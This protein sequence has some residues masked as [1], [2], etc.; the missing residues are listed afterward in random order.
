MCFIALTAL[1]SFR[2]KPDSLNL[3]IKDEFIQGWEDALTAGEEIYYNG[4]LNGMP[5]LERVDPTKFS[6]DR[7]PNLKNVEDGEWC[8]RRMTM[9]STSIYDRFYDSLC[10]A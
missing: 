5:T 8:L 7:D 9:T 3:A 10:E 2:L 6:Y 4:I 1:C